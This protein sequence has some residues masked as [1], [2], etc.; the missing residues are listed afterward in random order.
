MRP[1]NLE[2]SWD[3]NKNQWLVRIQLGE[4]VTRRH[5]AAPKSADD[6][7]LRSAVK[8]VVEDEGFEADLGQLTIRR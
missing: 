5:C 2:V 6:Q 1:D 3:S 4:E 8:Q 7:A